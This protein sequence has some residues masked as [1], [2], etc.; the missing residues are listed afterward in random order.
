MSLYNDTR[1][2]DMISTSYRC[3]WHRMHHRTAHGAEITHP[4]L[5]GRY[6]ILVMMWVLRWQATCGHGVIGTLLLLPV[7]QSDYW[8]HDTATWTDHVIPAP[9]RHTVCCAQ[10]RLKIP[11]STTDSFP[12]HTNIQRVVWPELMYR[13]TSNVPV[14][15]HR[16]RYV[17][18]PA[19]E[20]KIC[21]PL[22]R[23]HYAVMGFRGNIMQ[24]W[25]CES[26]WE[27]HIRWCGGACC[28]VDLR[29]RM[30]T[31]G[32]YTGI[33]FPTHSIT[34]ECIVYFARSVGNS[35]GH[36]IAHSQPYDAPSW[37]R[38]DTVH[39]MQIRENDCHHRRIAHIHLYCWK[40]SHECFHVNKKVLQGKRGHND[41]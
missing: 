36:S 12:G 11:V 13:Y 40:T 16:Y 5:A 27:P 32:G 20:V 6:T 4:Q 26:P 33:S 37:Q 8:Y 24:L 9:V 28:C 31:L 41:M 38:F 17:G 22:K 21:Q 3:A 30:H 15:G 19:C 34:H 18:T 14:R 10:V 7:R 29:N 35:H 2:V 25:V 1:T 23:Q 39:E